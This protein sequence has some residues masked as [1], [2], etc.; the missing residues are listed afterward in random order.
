MDVYILDSLLRRTVLVDKYLSFIWTE[1]FASYGDFELQLVS[2][3][4]YRRLFI[5]GTLLACNESNYVMRVSTVENTTDTE[6]KNVLKLTGVSLEALL[7]DRVAKNVLDDLTDA[8]VWTITDKP[9]D[10][11]RKIFHDVCV[12]GVLNVG[13]IIPFVIED[14][15]MPTDTIPEPTDPITVELEPQTVYAAIKD[16]CDQWTLGF[17]LLRN[18]DTSQLYFNIYA[19]SDRTTSQQALGAVVFSPELDT[20]QNTSELTSI[21]NYKNV[22][23]VF[24]PAGFEVVYPQDVIPDTSGFERHVLM[25][26]ADDITVDNPDVSAALI[27]RGNQELAKQRSFSAFDGEIAPN[28]GYKYGVHY[29]LG[30][31]VEMRN[32]DGA[33][34]LMRVTEQIF[35]S[36]GE[37]ERAYPTL[38]K[39]IFIDTGSWLSWESNQV[40][41]DFTTEHWSEL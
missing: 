12:T 26:R 3:P 17:R 14:T 15:F 25:V 24:S 23:Y 2:T 27:Q 4:D 36:D 28:S 39:N 7:D 41:A 20:L 31:L 5:T 30:D 22:A 34:N 35:V 10:V 21:A 8:P 37:G 32:V 6:G 18:G 1:R 11:A 33:T 19:G 40:W 38:A 16:I 9:A 29:N 13:D